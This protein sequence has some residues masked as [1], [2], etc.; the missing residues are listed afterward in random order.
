MN[1]FFKSC[2]LTVINIYSL[3]IAAK[4]PIHVPKLIVHFAK[5]MLSKIINKK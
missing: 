2:S 3:L 5:L 1:G 4:S